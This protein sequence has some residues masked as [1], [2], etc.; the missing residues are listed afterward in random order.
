MKK[1]AP[2]ACGALPMHC[3]RRRLQPPRG[4][5]LFFQLLLL[6]LFS[7]QQ[8][9]MSG[10]AI[11]KKKIVTFVFCLIGGG[12]E[13]EKGYRRGAWR[14]SALQLGGR[15]QLG[16]NT[17]PRVPGLAGRRA[18]R[19]GRPRGGTGAGQGTPGCTWRSSAP[20]E[21]GSPPGD[22]VRPGERT[23]A[24][25]SLQGAPRLPIAGGEFV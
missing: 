25:R 4:F 6:H 13:R 8:A 5:P 21:P 24:A 19:G 22:S 1:K 11:N 9:E 3:A 15:G 17:V 18:R 12:R 16:D 7:P 2:S 23:A 20:P 10:D 14:S